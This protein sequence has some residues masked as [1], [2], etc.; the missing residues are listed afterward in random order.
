[1]GLSKVADVALSDIEPVRI[2]RKPMSRKAAGENTKDF[3]TPI[4]HNPKWDRI[5]F[6]GLF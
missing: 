3:F 4:E 1:M 2:K 6:F 5:K